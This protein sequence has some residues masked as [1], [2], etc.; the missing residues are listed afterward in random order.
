MHVQA[1]AA[2]RLDEKGRVTR[3]KW[4]CAD[5][6]ADRWIRGP[7]EADV[8]EV[9]RWLRLGRLVR[10][11]WPLPGG[12][13]RTQGP[14]LRVLKDEDGQPTIETVATAGERRS[15]RHIRNF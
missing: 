2:V 5:T 12:P 11:L 3:V 10:C 7:W 4:G 8:M 6:T 1:V 15:L 9:V 13:G 14:A